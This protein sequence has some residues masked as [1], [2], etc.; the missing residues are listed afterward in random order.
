MIELD[1][2]IIAVITRGFG[3][4]FIDRTNRKFI[5]KIMLD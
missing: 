4:H 3:I 5:K 1:W 2:N